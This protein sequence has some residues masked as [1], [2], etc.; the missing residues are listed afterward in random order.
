MKDYLKIMQVIGREI[1]DSRGN[2][3]VEAEVTLADGSVGRAAVPSGASTGEFEALELRDGDQSKY[4]GKGV[5]KA[6]GNINEVIA[7]ALVGEDASDSYAVDAVMLELDG[8]DDKSKLGA[9]AILAVS[10]AAAKAAA[11]SEDIPLYRFFG[12]VSGNHLPVPMMNILNGGAHATNSVDTQEF[13]VMPVGAP[14]FREG[15]R[16]ATEVFHALQSL[17]KK[18]GNTTAVGDEG[19]FAPD[20]KSDEDTIEHILTAIRNAGYEPG[21]DFVL[22]MDAAA[23]EWKDKEKGKGHYKQPKS[24]RTFTS[25][26]LIAHWESLIGKYPIYSIEDGLDEEDWEGWQRMTKKLGDKVQLVGDDLF[27]TNTKRLKKGIDLGCANSILIK[28]NQIGS[29]TETLEAIKMAHEAG[30]TAIVSHRSGETED[31]TIADLAVALD[32]NQIKT[33][34]PSRSERVAKYNQLLRIEEALGKSA[35]F[36]G[37]RAFQFQK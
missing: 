21:R 3:T 25:D 33:G 24:G 7:P 28:L 13:M 10:L 12:G 31:T 8:T 26:E 5:S 2:P 16:W 19:G 30:Y 23:S 35:V 32:T 4:G 34:A 6:V 14:T 15:L 17:L 36:P 18:E 1:I 29:L 9:N 11:I 27:V 22:A 20:L 37:K